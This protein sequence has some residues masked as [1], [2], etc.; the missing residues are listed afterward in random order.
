ME[1]TLYV[2]REFKPVHNETAVIL[3]APVTLNPR[4][5][6]IMRQMLQSIIGGEHLLLELLEWVPMVVLNRYLKSVFL[7][8]NAS[9]S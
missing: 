2:S 4:C 8:L 7:N 5:I 3:Q 1:M 9:F 6:Y